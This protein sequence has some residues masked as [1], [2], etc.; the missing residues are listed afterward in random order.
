MRRLDRAFDRLA[1]RGGRSDPEVVIERLEARLAGEPTVVL[2]RGETSM[3]RRETTISRRRG[4]LIAATAMG[5][6]LLVGL[7]LLFLRGGNEVTP[8]T[9]VP[10]T[11]SM[12]AASTTLP[13]DTTTI[14]GDSTTVAADTTVPAQAALTWARLADTT[15]A[16]A[17]E[18]W[19]YVNQ[20]IAG[21]PGLVA[22]GAADACVPGCWGDFFDQE[23]I[24]FDHAGDW[25]LHQG[26]AVWLSADGE[27]WTQVPPEMFGDGVAMLTG[28]ADNGSRLVAVGIT[29]VRGGAPDGTLLPSPAVWVSDDDGASWTPVPDDEAAFGGEG[30][31]LMWS[32]IATESGFTAAGDDLWTSP[33]G[34]SWTRVGP[35]DE[36]RRIARTP[37]GYVAVGPSGHVAVLWTSPDAIAWTRAELP[38]LPTVDDVQLWSAMTDAIAGPGGVVVVGQV[39]RTTSGIVGGDFPNDSDGAVWVAGEGGEWLRVGAESQAFTDARHQE[40]RGVAAVGEHLV[41]VGTQRPGTYALYE[42]GDWRLSDPRLG[43]ALAW[44]SDDGG[45]TWVRVRSE[46]LGRLGSDVSMTA[47]IAFEGRVIAMGNDGRDLAVWIGTWE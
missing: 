45:L 23:R 24:G 16:L 12:P 4:I 22:V 8:A 28:V 29:A 43:P 20:V 6:A 41:A 27:A 39:Q 17:G 32:V 26:G 21:G 47:V 37:D 5:V 18:G 7:P 34:S 9:T 46:A 13:A 33:D 3:D 36:V 11:T 15:G 14:P 35:M 44:A 19:D 1:N 38:E 25:T 2:M 10:G 42:E 31:H 30:R 40:I